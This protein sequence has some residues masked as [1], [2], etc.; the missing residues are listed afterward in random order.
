M[1][2]ENRIST[3]LLRGFK[4]QCPNCGKGHLFAGYLKVAPVC[5]VCGNNNGQYRADDAPPYFTILIVGHLVIGPM[6]A[7]SFI[8][9]W[10]VEIVLATTLPAMLACTLGLLPLVKGAVI[11]FHWA[12]KVVSP[13]E[14]VRP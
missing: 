13:A 14:P 9:T 6:L 3:G 8:W 10:P 5:D 11:G 12:N 1:Q 2:T 7:F 4:R